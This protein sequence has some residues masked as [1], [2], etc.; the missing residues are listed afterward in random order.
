[1]DFSQN[2]FRTTDVQKTGIVSCFTPSNLQYNTVRG[3]RIT[4][5]EGLGLQ[6]LPVRQLDLSQL[7]DNQLRDLA[8]NAMT[9]TVVTAVILAGLIVFYEILNIERR[10]AIL[11]K[12]LDA[13]MPGEKKLFE[14]FADPAEFLDTPVSKLVE[15][16]SRTARLC[17]C[18]GREEKVSTEFQRCQL[19][20]HTTCIKCR[21]NPKHKY[22]PIDQWVTA[23]RLNPADTEVLVKDSL[24]KKISFSGVF[25]IEKYLQ[26]FNSAYKDR[27]T[28][29][30]AVKMVKD[31]L[32]SEVQYRG[33][34]RR[35]VWDFEFDSTV[36][37]LVLTISE[38]GAQ[39][40]LYSK[41]PDNLLVSD[42]ARKHF[43]K[44]PIARMKPY[45]ELIIEGEWEFWVPQVHDFPVTIT[46]SGLLVEAFQSKIGLEKHIGELVFSNIN[47]EFQ[48][49][50]IKEFISRDLDGDFKHSPD[51]GQA[52]D[53]THIRTTGEKGDSQPLLLF[54][55]HEGHT[56]D[57]NDHSYVLTLNGR[58]LDVGERRDIF[59]RFPTTWRQY[60]TR[61]KSLKEHREQSIISLDG[62]WIKLQ[63]YGIAS[64]VG[65]ELFMYNHIPSDVYLD[66]KASCTKHHAV[67]TCELSLDSSALSVPND[68]WIPVDRNNQEIVFR[69][70]AWALEK[71]KVLDGHKSENLRKMDEWQVILCD[72]AGRCEICAPQAPP[73]LW[74]FEPTSKG[75]RKAKQIPFE[76][77][78]AATDFEIAHKA[79]PSGMSTLFRKNTSGTVE[80]KIGINPKT[81]VHRAS[82]LLALEGSSSDIETSWCLVTDD[83]VSLR[84]RLDPF[85]LLNTKDEEFASQPPG[86]S[87]NVKLR[88]EQC[89]KLT[90]MINQEQGAVF[91][92]REFVETRAPRLGYLVMGQAKRERV[93]RGGILADEVGFGK[94][95]VILA[96]ILSRR[97]A[98][99]NFARRDIPGHIPTK[100][101]VIFIPGHLSKQWKREAEKFLAKTPKRTILV[102]ETVS[103]LSKLKVEDF[104]KAAII[105]VNCSVC[106]SEQYVLALAQLSGMVEPSSTASSRAK[107]AWS[108]TAYRSLERTV[109]ILKTDPKRIAKYLRDKFDQSL[110]EAKAH[111]LPI[112]SKRYT[113]SR[114]QEEQNKRKRGG[115]KKPNVEIIKERIA[116]S[117][118][119]K[120]LKN[121]D[122]LKFPV[123]E[124]FGFARVVVDEINYVKQAESITVM[125]V[126]GNSYWGLSGTPLKEGFPDVKTMARFLQ[127]NL[128]A[129][130][131]SRMKRD[132]YVQAQ[133]EMTGMYYNPNPVN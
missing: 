63:G 96:L 132:V 109:D 101:T 127:I 18:E 46:S 34:R 42:A 37:K 117:R 19:C 103:Q 114:F 27:K 13:S 71:G 36:S 133:S 49:H 83:I 100:A 61:D 121:C 53:S 118:N 70:I 47:I 82:A 11:E 124:M 67:L 66:Q 68:K 55:D 119:L 92:E 130:D 81:L 4:G 26:E 3:G 6:G 73:L 51:C 32:L 62:H 78:E 39:W 98:D 115:A 129:D 43:S 56:G 72:D 77:P 1:M 30:F 123:F 86:F 91:T 102:I 48:D 110:E 105:I 50:Q 85:I 41:V 31:A 8:G 29:N 65:L 25:D 35:E 20:K 125:N 112:P 10:E 17:Y 45:G 75:N 14:K 23:S 33:A 131:Y 108:K 93:V 64:S 120:A 87:T 88:P 15:S 106:Q 90:W 116:D 60:V 95:V 126:L 128:G 24:P 16:V 28:Q 12:P 107:S 104:M 22:E 38:F 76:M 58:R 80:V 89:K 2:T 9:S 7:V 74:T 111:D 84:P 40:L 79:R 69:H 97:T 54:F 94:T 44:H 122:D 21:R 57:P 52:F 99:E 113:G 5:L 59:A